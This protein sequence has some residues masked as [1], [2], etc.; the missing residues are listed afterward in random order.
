MKRERSEVA[1]VN[2]PSVSASL[3]PTQSV[4]WVQPAVAALVFE[5]R[6]GH[7]FSMCLMGEVIFPMSRC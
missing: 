4:S 1:P 7:Y 2:M 3:S 6:L 5:M